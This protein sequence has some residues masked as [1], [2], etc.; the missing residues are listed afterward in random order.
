MFTTQGFLNWTFLG[1]PELETRYAT[2][3]VV[4][5]TTLMICYAVFMTSH[6]YR[7]TPPWS[8]PSRAPRPPHELLPA[9][10]IP[11]DLFTCARNEGL[12]PALEDQANNPLADPIVEA[13]SS[14]VEEDLQVGDGLPRPQSSS[15]SVQQEAHL[16]SETAEP[17]SE[18][19]QLGFGDIDG[20][21]SPVPLAVDSEIESGAS[22]LGTATES[23]V[24]IQE[25]LSATSGRVADNSNESQP[26]VEPVDSLVSVS[27][28]SPLQVLSPPD[29]EASTFLETPFLLNVDSGRSLDDESTLGA[30]R[31]SED[32]A[33]AAPPPTA[34]VLTESAF[35]SPCSEPGSPQGDTP[36]YIM[37]SALLV[38]AEPV[39]NEDPS[40]SDTV[41]EL[42]GEDDWTSVDPDEPSTLR[43]SSAA[44]PHSG[45]G[46]VTGAT[47]DLTVS[48]VLLTQSQYVSTI[49]PPIPP[50][51]GGAAS[52]TSSTSSPSPHPRVHTSDRP[53]WAV[54]PQDEREEKTLRRH[55]VDS[56]NWAVAPD[57]E[58]VNNSA[59][60]DKKKGRKSDP[61]SGARKT[62]SR[63][64][65]TSR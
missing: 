26:N 62:K 47:N 57:S 60:S 22:L 63:R 64:A 51:D 39:T 53:D 11:G 10:N 14:L 65:W 21:V 59:S 5:A 16:D 31:L 42:N 38:P 34:D 33:V 46:E 35:E 56:P 13:S 48:A 36:S 24:D 43:A 1:A 61:G 18:E 32:D 52:P 15:I 44:D 23:R 12:A 4:L 27:G 29:V 58:A 17:K 6:R 41:A 55:S 9:K 37:Q 40:S 8:S 30:E 54:A 45:T 2:I 49:L 7:L 50:S 3:L 25:M 28:H 20:P 19:P